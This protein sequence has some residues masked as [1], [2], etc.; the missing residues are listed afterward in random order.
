[1]A[2]LK[3]G[4]VCGV[5][6]V[7]G[8]V[9]SLATWNKI[10]PVT[11]DSWAYMTGAASLVRGEGYLR[12]A[13]GPQVLY[14]PGYSLAIALPLMVLGD[15][16]VAARLVSLVLSTA[17]IALL[18]LVARRFLSPHW[19]AGAAVLFAALPLRVKLS[20]MVWSE[21]SYLFFVLLGFLALWKWYEQKRA[22]WPAATGLALGEAYLIR[23]EAVGV[24]VI[25]LLGGCATGV[26]RSRTAGGLLA[27]LAA[28][29]VAALPYVAYL[30]AHTGR[31]QL[32][33]KSE[34]NLRVAQGRDEGL[35]HAEMFRLDEKGNI[36]PARVRLVLRAL[37]A[38]IVRNQ[39]ITFE[40]LAV[41][42]SPM[43]YAFVGAGLVVAF[44]GSPLRWPL[45]AT[46]LGLAAPLIHVSVLHVIHRLL[47][48]L[49]VLG[50]ILGAAGIGGSVRLA[51]EAYRR[52]LG[53]LL[54]GL[55][56]ASL[57]VYNVRSN[58][59]LCA[60]VPRT[61]REVGTWIAEHFPERTPMLTPTRLAGY[62][63]HKTPKQLP[64]APLDA[65]V[66]YAERQ[67]ASLMLLPK[68]RH[69][70]SVCEFAQKAESTPELE[71]VREWE[72]F[73]LVRLRSPSPEPG[74]H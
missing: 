31:W 19:A 38:R 25:A 70:P 27:M 26:G 16:E 64:Y 40:R 41:L 34:M 50:V 55:A 59:L 65:I 49:C 3:P 48:T 5:A 43:V 60:P 42:L 58:H 68:K 32:T 2:W 14:P 21:S 20:T 66:P 4:H 45:F 24:L 54:G 15:A 72:S 67:G 37:A 74:L 52:R 51:P 63:A 9:L 18:W 13:G 46:L 8:L 6:A 53:V 23:P 61:E 62:W 17:S 12:Y 28:F 29:A 33:T 36:A 71:V 35:S 69:E 44:S 30:H 39:I 73:T 47:F 10:E 57:L 22:I 11:A 56:V 7:L 1:M